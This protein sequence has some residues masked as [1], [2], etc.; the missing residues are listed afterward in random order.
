MRKIHNL[1]NRKTIR[2]KLRNSSTPHEVIL[3][4][5]IRRGRLGYKLRRQ[6][7]IGKYI[8]DFY[9]P[10]KKLII[11]VDGSQHIEQQREYDKQ[12]DEY[13]KNLGFTMLRFWD[14]DIDNNLDGVLMKISEYLK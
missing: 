6:H 2:R 9:C 8:V 10:K 14:N 7:S 4:S 13:L 12:R 3:W 5:R 11:E 1:E